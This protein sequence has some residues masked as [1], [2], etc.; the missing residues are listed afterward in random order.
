MTLYGPPRNRAGV[1]L[2]R[3]LPPHGPDLQEPPK[4]AGGL[5]LR[6]RQRGEPDQVGGTWARTGLPQA[7][8]SATYNVANHQLTFGGQSLTYDLNGNLTSD[9]S[10]TYTW[11]A[12]NRLASLSGPGATASFQYDP[13]GRRTR[14]T[15][16]GT[17]TDLVYDGLNPVEEIGAATTATLLTGLGIDEYFTRTDSGGTSALLTDALG[18]TVALTVSG[19]VDGE[20][21]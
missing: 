21:W 8:S 15:I 11:D 19:M 17:T 4:R 9:G 13:L 14:K 18:S 1:H 2:R 20:R 3:R 7:V 16:A 12:R 10:T 5:D 6:L